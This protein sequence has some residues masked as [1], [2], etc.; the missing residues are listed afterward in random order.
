MRVTDTTWAPAVL[1]HGHNERQ[2]GFPL[3]VSR[4]KGAVLF[5][6][7][8]PIHRLVPKMKAQP[9][10]R[11]RPGSGASEKEVLGSGRGRVSRAALGCSR[12]TPGSAGTEGKL[13]LCLQRLLR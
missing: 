4:S 6:L 12:D 10:P 9:Y 3:E 7:L 11:M 13:P 2:V 5:R 1:A 8:D